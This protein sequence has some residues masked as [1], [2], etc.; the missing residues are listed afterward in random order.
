LASNQSARSWKRSTS[1]R[2]ARRSEDFNRYF[3]QPSKVTDPN[4]KS[5]YLDYDA[6]GRLAQVWKP[7]QAGT[8][9]GSLPTTDPSMKFTYTIPNPGHSVGRPMASC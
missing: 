8:V 7:K 9:S 2:P 4:G 3:G 5:T 1:G 6:A